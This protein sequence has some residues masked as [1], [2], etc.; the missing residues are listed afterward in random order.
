MSETV[1]LNHVKSMICFVDLVAKIIHHL[2]AVGNSPSPV[3]FPDLDSVRIE[4]DAV[5]AAH[6]ASGSGVPDQEIIEDGIGTPYR[7]GAVHLVKLD[8]L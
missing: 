7:A 3:N 2:I 5:L 4:F 6:I 1:F 8:N